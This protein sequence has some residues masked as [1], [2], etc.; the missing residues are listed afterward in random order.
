MRDDERALEM[1]PL[2]KCKRDIKD[3][4]KSIDIEWKALVGKPNLSGPEAG[5]SV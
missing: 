3:K 4:L 1:M 2:E 5:D